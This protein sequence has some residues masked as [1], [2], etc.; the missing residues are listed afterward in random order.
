MMVLVGILGVV[1]LICAIYVVIKMFSEKGALHGILGLLCG[2]Y[3]FIW[4]W[5]NADRLDMRNIMMG[6][7]AAVLLNVVVSVMA[8]PS[9]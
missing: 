7:T 4:G 2:L 9:F 8:Q 3:A 1:N 5:Q 6:W